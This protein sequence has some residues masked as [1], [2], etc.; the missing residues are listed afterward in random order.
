MDE[1]A[2]EF[3]SQD[4]WDNWLDRLEEAD[5]EDDDESSR[6]Y[7]NLQNDAA[8]AIAKILRA[9][10]NG[11]LSEEEAIEEI[12]EVHSIVLAEPALDDE[13]AL[14]LIDA[15]QTSM[16]SAFVAS[17]QYLIEDEI[18]TEPIDELIDAA[19]TAEEAEELETA[20]HYIA[21][22]GVAIIDGERLDF[23][24]V[25]EL[26]YGLVTEWLGGL[27]SLQ[28]ALEGPKVVDEE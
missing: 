23:T 13:E 24:V 4:R 17:E 21:E 22:V 3:Y 19:I 18:E 28:D 11:S 12:D 10:D 2:V 1:D 8:I 9:Y 25:E 6:L 27:D 7:L 14:M 20:M 5:L 16:V 26:E 15:V